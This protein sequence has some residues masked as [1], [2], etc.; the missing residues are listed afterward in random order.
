VLTKRFLSRFQLA[1][2]QSPHGRPSEWVFRRSESLAGSQSMEILRL[3][4]RAVLFIGWLS[5]HGLGNGVGAGLIWG[6]VFFAVTAANLRRR[7]TKTS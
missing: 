2:G 1:V 5:F 3:G 6:V 4:G 7:R